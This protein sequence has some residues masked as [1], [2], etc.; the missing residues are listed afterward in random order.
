MLEHLGALF[1]LSW[2]IAGTCL[3]VSICLKAW[4]VHV[5]T[6]KYPALYIQLGSPAF[7]ASWLPTGRPDVISE[8]KAMSSG[9]LAA[10]HY[11]MVK[12]VYFLYV[13]GYLSTLALVICCNHT[14]LINLAQDDELEVLLR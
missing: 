3:L 7:F 1:W 13:I 5:L 12:S 14:D 2:S 9:M 6:T 10:H 4:L 8:L 11:R